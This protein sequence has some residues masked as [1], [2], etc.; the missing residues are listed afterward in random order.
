MLCK[1]F[2]ICVGW[3]RRRVFESSDPLATVEPQFFMMLSAA[4]VQ[5]S[6]SSRSILF[7]GTIQG[8]EVLVLID[9]GSSHSFIST[10]LASKLQGASIVSPAVSVKVSNG[11]MAQC[12]TQF[13][14]LTWSVQGYEFHS[15]FKVFPLL[16]YDVIVGMHWLE[17]H[18]PMRVHWLQKWLSI[19][20]SHSTVVLYGVDASVPIG[21][22]VHIA[23]VSDKESPSSSVP[24]EPALQQLLS[25][26]KDVFVVPTGLPPPRA[27]DHVIARCHTS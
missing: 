23:A 3:M 22:V 15:N 25:E 21:S 13:S 16:H 7:L 10:T 26:F 11:D 27:C 2:G 6:V 19:T 24:L 12:D 14:A 17:A 5:E 8:M 4:A 20:Y 9:S 18:S 1:R